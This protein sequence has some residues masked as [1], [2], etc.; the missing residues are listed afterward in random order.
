MRWVIA[1]IVA[2]LAWGQPPEVKIT[3]RKSTKT[4]EPESATDRKA[5]IRVDTTLVLIPVSVTTM[6]GTFV[7]AL[8]KEN[9]RVYEDR[10]A[11]EILTFSSQDVPMTIGIVFDT[12]GSM[13]DKLKRSRE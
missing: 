6:M 13:G 7:T 4:A 12:S 1:F 3:P 5:N 11:Q 8:E 9:F 2:G 10:V